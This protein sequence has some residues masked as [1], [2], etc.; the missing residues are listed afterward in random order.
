MINLKHE[1]RGEHKV[2][3]LDES[4]ILPLKMFVNAIG[5]I[6]IYGQENQKR[7]VQCF[8]SKEKSKTDHNHFHIKKEDICKNVCA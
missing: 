7:S 5:Q 6:F 1:K 2:M 4:Y 3:Y 8:E